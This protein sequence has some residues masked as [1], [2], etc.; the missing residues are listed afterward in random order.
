M[1]TKLKRLLTAFMAL[2]LVVSGLVFASQI[3]SPSVA[4]TES[5]TWQ[6]DAPKYVFLFIG[7]GMTFPQLTAA[8]DYLGAVAYEGKKVE[9]DPL[10]F[11][12]FSVAGN[13]TTFD[14]TSFCPDSASTATSISTGFK[15]LSG[16]INMDEQKTIAYETIA[17]KLKKQFGYKI[18]II[19]SVPLNHATPAAFYAHQPTRSNYYEIGLEM[20][21]SGFDYFG[22]GG[23]LVSTGKNGDQKEVLEVAK[24][25][26]YKV[27]NDTKSILNLSKTN[28]KVIAINPTLV[29]GAL[30]Y[31]LDRKS[32]DLS[33]ADF[34]RKGIDVLNNDR[35]FFMMVEGGKID[36]AC[37]AN[38]AKAS[39]DDTIAFDEAVQE[40]IKFYNKYPDETLIIV[41]GDHETGGL[42]IGY[43]GT[44]YSTYLNQLDAQTMSFEAYN[45]KVDTFRAQSASFDT[46]LLDI[47]DNFGLVTEVNASAT[48]YPNMVLSDLELSK[49]EKAYTLSMIDPD[50]RNLSEED[51]LLY[52]GYEP[53][54]VTITH[55]LNNKSG[56][57]WTSYSHTGLPTAVYA[58][59]VGASLFSGAYDNTDLFTKMATLTHV[60]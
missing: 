51:Y 9:N 60:K 23:L 30:P 36:W 3:S 8:S 19:S 26:G 48:A 54:S 28:D 16:V 34:T 25:S 24:D 31:E 22:G 56:I 50:A 41:T 1:K 44:K 52:G 14:S 5:S 12:N 11:M 21:D 4:S 53:L 37:H 29:G 13:A 35:G 17:E 40:A 43:A 2:T 49:L 6:G 39:I 46:V 15:T 10:A 33:L 27:Y 47:Q 57:G 59:G 32:G 18:G 38:D 58:E 42:T 20:I 7:D 45:E 55:L